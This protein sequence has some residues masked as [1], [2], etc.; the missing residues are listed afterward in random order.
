MKDSC[1]YNSDS[2]EVYVEVASAYMTGFNT[3]AG[4]DEKKDDFVEFCDLG[5]IWE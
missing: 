4:D 5:S 1:Y 2:R 3:A